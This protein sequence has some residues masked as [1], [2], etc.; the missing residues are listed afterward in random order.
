MRIM[1]AEGLAWRKLGEETIVINL[2]KRMMYGL[3]AEAGKLW[4]ALDPGL[5]LEAGDAAKN[6]SIAAFISDLVVEGLAS[7][8]LTVSGENSSADS[9]P[10]LLWKE[11]VQQFAGGCAFQ[12]G[13]GEPCDSAAFTS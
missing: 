11:E 12:S 8:D 10:K 9:G 1:R 13:Q 6:E 2:R 3:N 5:D 4:E 7:G